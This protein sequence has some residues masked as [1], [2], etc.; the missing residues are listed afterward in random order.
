MSNNIFDLDAR[1]AEAGIAPRTMRFA[2]REWTIPA[3]LPLLGLVAFD[4]IAKKQAADLDAEELGNAVRALLGAD[5]DAIMAAGFG[6]D[7]LVLLVEQYQLSP[8]EAEA[9]SPS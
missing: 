6:F 5:A 7:H 2:G 1:A 9:S 3:T 4:R 8:G